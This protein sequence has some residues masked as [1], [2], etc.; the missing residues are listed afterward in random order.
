MIKDT[1]KVITIAKI[2]PMIGISVGLKKSHTE[3]IFKSVF[4]ITTSVIGGPITGS[5]LYSKYTVE[6]AALALTVSENKMQITITIKFVFFISSLLYKRKKQ[7]K[8]E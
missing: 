2:N 7:G 6:L 5:G 4:G 8:S 3:L 1:V